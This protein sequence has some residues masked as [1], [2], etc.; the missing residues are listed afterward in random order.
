MEPTIPDGSLLI[1]EPVAP[2]LIVRGDIIAF[3]QT[4]RSTTRRVIAV[5]AANVADPMFTTKADANPVPDPEPTHFPG[6][7]AL[8]RASIPLLGY[9]VAYVQAYWRLA[10]LVIAAAVLL[11]CA[12]A[13]AASARPRLLIRPPTPAFAT[14]VVDSEDAWT[15]HMGWLRKRTF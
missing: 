7:V 12:T 6:S 10:L 11:A 3:D 5:D 9:L 8:Y 15:N 13:S 14:V 4:G 2:S 1:I